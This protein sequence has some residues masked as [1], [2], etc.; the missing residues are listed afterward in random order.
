MCNSKWLSGTIIQQYGAKGGEGGFRLSHQPIAPNTNILLVS[1]NQATAHIQLWVTDGLHWMYITHSGM[2]NSIFF[3]GYANLWR[4]VVSLENRVKSAAHS[5][6]QH[7]MFQAPIIPTPA[8]AL[9]PIIRI[10]LK[11]MLWSSSTCD[12][13]GTGN[14][15]GYDPVLDAQIRKPPPPRSEPL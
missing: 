4:K 7:S 11:F 2:H 9:I 3:G 10:L 14:S 6:C 15:D 1:T 13:F 5:R 8:P 12:E